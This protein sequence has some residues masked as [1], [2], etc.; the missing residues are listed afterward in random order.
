[1]KYFKVLFVFI[2]IAQVSDGQQNKVPDQYKSIECTYGDLTEDGV[3]E[4]VV[5]YNVD[6][7]EDDINGVNREIIIFRQVNDVWTIWHRSLTAVENSKD[8]G[9]RGDPFGS[10]EIKNGVLLINQNGGSSWKWSTTDKYRYQNNAFELIGYSSYFGKLC[11]YWQDVDFNL[12]TGKIELKKEYEKCEDNNE[13][14]DTDK[15][16]NETFIHKLDH[17]ILLE[18][19]K[20]QETKI[21]S[22][23]YKHD[24]YL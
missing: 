11:E 15:P 14:Q 21:V 18:S 7:I 20:A 19:R 17:K 4:K 24:I 13:S 3:P 12:M 9:M 23:K 5:V 22:P 16:E 6:S 10:I 1:M 8:G 2:S